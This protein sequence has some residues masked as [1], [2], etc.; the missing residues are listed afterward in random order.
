M[1]RIETEH[2]GHTIHWSDNEDMWR[3]S[4]LDLSNTS[5]SRLKDAINKRYLQLRK[6]SSVKAY[7]LQ[8]GTDQKGY[9]LH[10]V[11]ITEVLA[12]RRGE[13]LPRVATMSL[14]GKYGHGDRQQRST[15][16]LKDIIRAHTEL[17]DMLAALNKAHAASVAADR[18]VKE[19]KEAFERI[20]LDDMPDLVKA[21]H[22]KLEE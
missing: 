6:A 5:L 13:K 14:G 18:R 1:S 11:T 9:R 16:E 21:G 4:D 12:V 22:T 20:T 8:S 15:C 2:R 10:P 19:L 7:M 17:D 3:C